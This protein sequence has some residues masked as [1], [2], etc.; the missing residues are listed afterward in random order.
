M[1]HE[2]TNLCRLIREFVASFVDGLA[3]KQTLRF[4]TND[5]SER[6][7]IDP[8]IALGDFPDGVPAAWNIIFGQVLQPD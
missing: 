1:E 5:T 8:E 4:N 3:I 2:I 7:S 6:E